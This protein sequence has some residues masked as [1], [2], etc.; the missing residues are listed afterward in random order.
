[1]NQLSESLL[2]NDLKW[3]VL[4]DVMIDMHKTKLGKDKD[5]I[6]LAISVTDKQ[7]AEDLATFIENSVY[8]FDDVEVSGA[9]DT[10]GNYMIYV[11]LARNDQAYKT[12]HGI[13][14]DCS[15]L[16]GITEWKFKTTN[17]KN[18]I[19]LDEDSFNAHIITDPEEYIKFH[20]EKTDEE[21]QADAVKES[22]KS[23]F[24]F[25]LSY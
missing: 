22:I 12:V 19:V 11:E 4:D 5:Y 10:A 7:P 25:L 14:T 13:L 8:E 18:G 1:M 15:K 17:V 23:R 9:T 3:L 21:E 24:K 2:E 16:C 20:P 6:V